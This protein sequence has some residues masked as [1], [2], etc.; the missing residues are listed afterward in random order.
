VEPTVI[1]RLEGLRM[2]TRSCRTG[3]DEV[4]TFH[5]VVPARG[6][7]CFPFQDVDARRATLIF[8]QLLDLEFTRR[9]VDRVGAFCT[10]RLCGK[11]ESIMTIWW[12]LKCAG[13][14]EPRVSIRGAVTAWGVA[15]QSRTSV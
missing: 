8:M 4:D 2:W 13:T 9:V 7:R 14:S 6:P 1:E 15:P 11:G 5:A 12:Q 10:M 3:N